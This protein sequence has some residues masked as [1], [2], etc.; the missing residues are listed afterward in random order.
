MIPTHICKINQG[1]LFHLTNSETSP[2]WIKRGYNRFAKKYECCKYDDVN[3]EKLI[4]KK[5]TIYITKG[6]PHKK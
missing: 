2:I 6:T 1:T 4:S 3:H 5:Q